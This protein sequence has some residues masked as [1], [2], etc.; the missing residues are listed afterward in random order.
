MSHALIIVILG[1]IIVIFTIVICV[2]RRG[3]LGMAGV[4]TSFIIR[5]TRRTAIPIVRHGT[6]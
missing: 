3:I 2:I 5:A 1:S 6:T 4:I